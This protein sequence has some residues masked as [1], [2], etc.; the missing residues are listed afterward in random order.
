MAF[1]GACTPGG[2]LF[3]MALLTDSNINLEQPVWFIL[4]GIGGVAGW[5]LSKRAR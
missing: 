2:F 3:L 4:A 5:T 1:M